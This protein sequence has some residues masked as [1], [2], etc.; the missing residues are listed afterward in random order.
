MTRSTTDDRRDGTSFAETALKLGGKSADEARRTGA[1]DT[2]DDQVEALFAP[3]YQTVNSPAHRAVWDRGVPVELFTSTPP[4]DAA[5]RAAG[6]G[7][8][9]R[10]RA[11]ASTQAGTLLNDEGKIAE[12]VLADLGGAG[13]WGLLGRQGIRRLGRAVQLVRAVSHADGARRSDRRRPGVGARLHRRG[14]SGAHVR[15]R[16]AEAAIPAGTG[17]RLAAQRVRPHRAVRRQRSHGAAHDGAARRRR[18]RRQR[19]EAVHH[20][21][22]ARPHD[23]PGVPDRR[24]AGRADRRAAAARERALSAPQVRPVGAQAHVQ[25]RHHLPRLPRA[26]RRTCSRRRA[27]T[28]SRSPITG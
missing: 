11:A 9:D 4:T 13:Y 24:Q 1:I 3:E 25:P 12:P 7:R 17:R 16:R 8:L 20:Q 26:G 14:R 15:Q 18:L 23:R 28:G 27:A 10:R 19:R 21:C 6:D 2:A 5:R 22:R